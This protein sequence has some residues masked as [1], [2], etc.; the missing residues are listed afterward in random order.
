M[1][2]SLKALFLLTGVILFFSCQKEEKKDSIETAQNEETEISRPVQPRIE[3]GFNQEDYKFQHDTIHS[4]DSFGNIMHKYGLSAA[5]IHHINESVKD[6]FDLRKLNAGRP[7]IMVNHR[8]NP[9]S[10]AAFIYEKNKIEYAIIHLGDQPQVELK[11]HPVTLKRKAASGVIHSSLY[12]AMEQNGAS[13]ALIQELSAL[14]QWKIDFFRIQKGDKFKVIYNELYV[15]DTTY[16]GIKDIIA[17]Q[18]THYDEPYYAFQYGKDKAGNKGYYD[19]EAKALQSF[20]LKA[21]V[22]YTRISSR[23]TPK[24]FHPV[25]KR[26]KAHLGTDYAAPIGTPIHSTADGIVI[27]STFTKYNGN[28]VKVRHNSKYS[29]QYLHMSRRKAQVGQHIKQGEVI[30][31]VGQT[32]LATGPH[33]CYRFWVNGKQEDPFRQKM[34]T[35]EPLADSLK[36][37]YLQSIAPLKRELDKM[38]VEDQNSKKEKNN[39]A[40][41][42]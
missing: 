4:G 16:V 31:Y 2:N 6:S 14:Y 37:E 41:L 32:G 34:P 26:W 17:A 12:I 27:A 21:P 38:V 40:G 5:E 9:D 18:F 28:Y 22:E 35:S 39:Y 11:K 23:Y 20:F 13:P 1:K 7:Y 10:L 15:N 42:P 8:D 3:F 24:R 36:P 19:E 29:T 33:V 30:G 25:Q